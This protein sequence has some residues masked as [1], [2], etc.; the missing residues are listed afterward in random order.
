MPT[1][2]YPAIIDRSATG[3]GVT[4][5]DFPGCIASGDTASE[6]CV[7]AEKALALH[8]EAM[9]KDKDAIPEPSSLD[10]IEPVDGADDVARV[11]IR[12]EV[13]AK[14]ERVLVSIDSNLLHAIDTVAPNRS[15]FFADLARTA[16]SARNSIWGFWAFDPV[17]NQFVQR[18][19]A[20]G[21]PLRYVPAP[22]SEAEVMQEAATLKKAG[23]PTSDVNEFSNAAVDVLWHKRKGTKPLESQLW[24]R[25]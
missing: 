20:G 12:A 23:V 14:V 21:E 25:A 18:N 24:A 9:T 7:Q 13:P 6:A 10:A 15:A 5:V 8:V 3:F 2:Y 1:T 17:G 4:F 19:P 16:L 22:R 11:M